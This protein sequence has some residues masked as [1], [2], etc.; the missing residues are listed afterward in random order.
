MITKDTIQLDVAEKTNVANTLISNIVHQTIAVV[1]ATNDAEV[2]DATDGF[3]IA[4]QQL[5][6]FVST[7][8]MEIGNLKLQSISTVEAVNNIDYDGEDDRNS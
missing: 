4:S 7:L 1:K 3:T 8:I 6:K 2:N 5:G